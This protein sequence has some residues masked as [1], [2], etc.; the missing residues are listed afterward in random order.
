MLYLETATTMV[1]SQL[2]LSQLK[3][4]WCREDW[5]GAGAVTNE[6][7]NGVT[8]GARP[9]NPAMNA[10][11]LMDGASGATDNLH[12]EPIIL[13]YL[14]LVHHFPRM[15]QQRTNPVKPMSQHREPTPTSTTATA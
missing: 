11:V 14:L 3:A 15:I 6:L 8:R 12:D 5:P 7:F 9:T 13:D 10:C 4:G 1:N 2:L